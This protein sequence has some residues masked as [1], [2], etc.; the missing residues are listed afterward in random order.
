MLEIMFTQIFL[1]LW[2]HHSKFHSD[3]MLKNEQTFHQRHA[4]VCILRHNS[5]HHMTLLLRQRWFTAVR[6]KY[7][8]SKK[9]FL[10]CWEVTP[11]PENSFSSH[12]TKGGIM[13][14]VWVY[15]SY[16][17]RWEGKKER[18][19]VGIR[20]CLTYNTCPTPTST[21]AGDQ[22]RSTYLGSAD[23]G[24]GKANCVQQVPWQSKIP[25]SI[26]LLITHCELLYTFQVVS[27]AP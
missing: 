2:Y 22:E 12:C 4:F 6:N 15:V 24:W 9:S 11:G 23:R 13:L 19:I 20:I 3:E 17:S 1:L 18:Q 14:V 21:E 27:M 16:G 25:L 8:C 10:T 26:L 5:W 7:Q